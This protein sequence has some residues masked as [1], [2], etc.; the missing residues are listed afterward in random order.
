M[1][2]ED[3]YRFEITIITSAQL[4]LPN[5]P[6]VTLLL[7][8]FINQSN[9]SSLL[10]GKLTLWTYLSL[11][12][13]SL[14]HIRPRTPRG[15]YPYVFHSKNNHFPLLHVLD[16]Q[17]TYLRWP[18]HIKSDHTRTH[19]T[20]THTYTH[21]TLCVCISRSLNY[22]FFFILLSIHALCVSI[23]RFVCVCAFFKLRDL[24]SFIT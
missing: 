21:T 23:N 17:K 15:P 20:Q 11:L 19:H 16:Y 7:Q 24:Y 10:N 2:Y 12:H 18:T 4:F 9:I 22:C 8:H 6:T 1:L 3:P 13:L 5:S 14:S